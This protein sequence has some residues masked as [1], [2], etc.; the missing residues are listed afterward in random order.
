ME[1]IQVIKTE[2]I[3]YLDLSDLSK[4]LLVSKHIRDY[5]Y[6]DKIWL[7]FC[8]SDYKK[9]SLLEQIPEFVQILTNSPV[10]PEL[11]AYNNSKFGNEYKICR[12]LQWDGLKYINLI[13]LIQV[14]SKDLT[15]LFPIIN[16]LNRDPYRIKNMDYPQFMSFLSKYKKIVST[17]NPEYL[18]YIIIT[19]FYLKKFQTDKICFILN[20]NNSL[21]QMDQI[22]LSEIKIINNEYYIPIIFQNQTELI[23]CLLSNNELTRTDIKYGKNEQDFQFCEDIRTHLWYLNGRMKI[24][25]FN[26]EIFIKIFSELKNIES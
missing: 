24:E 17:M 26:P 1:I 14:N 11:Q 19:P 13:N 3:Q 21:Q 9:R 6:Q 23:N 10:Y 25:N 8:D 12:I 7:K 20:M 18:K 4:I 2:I 16:L 22:Y 15:D 5:V